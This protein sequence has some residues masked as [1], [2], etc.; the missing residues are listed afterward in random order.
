VARRG[1]KRLRPLRPAPL[2]RQTLQRAAAK[3]GDGGLAANSA[4]NPTSA[5]YSEVSRQDLPR[6]S[7][8]ILRL[9]SNSSHVV[10]FAALGGHRDGGSA[11]MNR[12]LHALSDSANP[13]STASRPACRK[14]G[15][16]CGQNRCDPGL[17]CMRRRTWS[18]ARR[19]IE[20]FQVFRAWQGKSDSPDFRD[21]E[22]QICVG[23]RWCSGSDR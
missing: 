16:R 15:T 5:W 17:P 14:A 13:A 7:R 10:G 21:R 9:P 22:I 11:T 19:V 3:S 6:I 12:A 20:E 23:R 4:D 8:L 18:V 1:R 2:A